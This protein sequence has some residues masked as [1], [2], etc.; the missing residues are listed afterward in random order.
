MIGFHFVQPILPSASDNCTAHKI[1]AQP[2]GPSAAPRVTGQARGEGERNG[3]SPYQAAAS[4][5]VP[6]PF[7]VRLLR[8]SENSPEHPRT[9]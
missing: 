2:I 7:L 1:R 4:L 5:F 6:A 3:R 9:L 8:V